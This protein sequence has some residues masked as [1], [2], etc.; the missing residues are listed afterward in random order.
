MHKFELE[1]Y[2]K[3][4]LLSNGDKREEGHAVI[5]IH[6]LTKCTTNMFVPTV[7]ASVYGLYA[8]CAGKLYS[9]E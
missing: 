9:L 8:R 2:Y 5:E 7:V 3:R 4:K 1:G 6:V